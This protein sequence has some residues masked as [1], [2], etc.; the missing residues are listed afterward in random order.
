MHTMTAPPAAGLTRGYAAEGD[1]LL[2]PPNPV[3]RLSS[4]RIDPKDQRRLDLHAALTA[5]GIPPSPGDSE[6]IERLSDL[7][8][9]VHEALHRWLK[10]LS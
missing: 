2:A 8:V 7:P 3:D 10:T 9:T 5:A 6:A 4:R 1:F